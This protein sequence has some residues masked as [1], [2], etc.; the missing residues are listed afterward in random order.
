MTVLKSMM[1][2]GVSFLRQGPAWHLAQASATG[3][4]ALAEGS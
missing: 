4:S 3:R 1:A 2:F